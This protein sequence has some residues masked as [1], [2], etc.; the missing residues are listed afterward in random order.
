MYAFEQTFDGQRPS[1]GRIILVRRARGV[2]PAIVTFINGT[3]SFF[4]QTLGREPQEC[5]CT[6]LTY[7]PTTATDVMDM[8]AG[9]WCWPPRT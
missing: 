5:T 8:P 2:E 9:A 1:L 4:A 7:H 6:A 3:A